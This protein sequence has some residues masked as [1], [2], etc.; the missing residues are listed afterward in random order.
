MASLAISETDEFDVIDPTTEASPGS[1]DID[2]LDEA[3]H[4]RGFGDWLNDLRLKRDQFLASQIDPDKAPSRMQRF[5]RSSK[6][7]YL[8]ALAFGPFGLVIAWALRRTLIMKDNFAIEAHARL[9]EMEAA[10][11]E[12]PD[13][14]TTGAGRAPSIDEPAIDVGDLEVELPAFTE[15]QQD[16]IDEV[17]MELGAQASHVLSRRELMSLVTESRTRMEQDPAVSALVRSVRAG[18]LG[19]IDDATYLTAALNQAGLDIHAARLMELTPAVGAVV[20]PALTPVQTAFSDD[21][22][23]VLDVRFGVVEVAAGSTTIVPTTTDARLARTVHEQELFN[24]VD[25]L[26]RQAIER[27]DA[28]GRVAV[29]SE[30]DAVDAKTFVTHALTS[31]G[32]TAVEQESRDLQKTSRKVAKPATLTDPAETLAHNSAAEIAKQTKITR[33]GAIAEGQSAG[34]LAQIVSEQRAAML[35]GL[36]PSDRAAFE[37]IL[38]AKSPDQHLGEALIVAGMVSEPSQ[39]V[40]LQPMER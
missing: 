28:L 30:L 34:V 15:L 32:W 35:D 4:P 12:V 18:E 25:D 39:Q 23:R 22:Q 37:R 17:A 31:R 29:A 14:R 26:K 13:P 6:W 36:S 5:T 33:V 40:V 1:A 2:A 20:V 11:A 19:A 7:F 10:R 38:D 27:Q 21:L 3:E 24:L 16:L 8:P 9:A